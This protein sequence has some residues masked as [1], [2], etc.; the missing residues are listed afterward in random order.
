MEGSNSS[1]EERGK[2]VR[3][4]ESTLHKVVS[5]SGERTT[6]DRPEKMEKQ[7]GI[8]ECRSVQE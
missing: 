4:W 2:R 8:Q 3:W 1:T 5:V 6:G 7:G